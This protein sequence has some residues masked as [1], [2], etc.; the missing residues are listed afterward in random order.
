MVV[1][2]DRCR[3]QKSASGVWPSAPEGDEPSGTELGLARPRESVGGRISVGS[4]PVGGKT[5]GQWRVPEA[6]KATAGSTCR[7]KALRSAEAEP[8][9]GGTADALLAPSGFPGLSRVAFGAI[10]SV[11]GGSAVRCAV[12][13]AARGGHLGCSIPDR[14][15][16]VADIAEAEGATSIA[17]FPGARIAARRSGVAENLAAS[18]RRGR[19][20]PVA[21]AAGSGIGR[22]SGDRVV[23]KLQTSGETHL[24]ASARGEP[25]GEPSRGWVAR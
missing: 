1:L 9:D 17:A 11:R 25:R 16:I 18:G 23:R 21:Q 10:G 4:W 5:A 7:W 3:L 13:N 2:V 20:G 8:L 22:S 6:A 12:D 19:G 15:G 14:V 24:S